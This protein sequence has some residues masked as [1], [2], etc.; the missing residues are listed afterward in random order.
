MSKQKRKHIPRQ[1][2]AKSKSS[3]GV[4]TGPEYPTEEIKWWREAIEGLLVAIVLALLIRGFEAEAFVIPTGSMAPTLRGRHKDVLCE[5]CGHDY[6]VGAS[7]DH[8]NQQGLVVMTT[9]PMCAYNQAIEY[10][11]SRDASV[12]GDRIL[13]NKFS[14][15]PMGQ[16]ERF[17]VIVFKNPNDAKQNY[18]KR[19]CGVPGDVLSIEEPHLYNHGKITHEPVIE[20]VAR[21]EDGYSGY[22]LAGS[23]YPTARLRKPTDQL[24]LR[25]DGDPAMREYAALG[26]NTGNSLDSRYWGQVRGFNTVGPALFALWPFTSGHWGFID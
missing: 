7:L 14:Y 22:Q 12:A 25:A 15:D 26:D 1:S 17:D 10:S 6:A 18:I 4:V 9:C 20:R 5:Q 24:R 3:A 21:A 13:V 8:E 23:N 16:P 2:E 11:K 19:L